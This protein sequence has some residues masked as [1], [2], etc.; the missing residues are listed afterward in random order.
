MNFYNSRN[1]HDLKMQ[2]SM[3]S[4][5]EPRRPVLLAQIA[6]PIRALVTSWQGRGARLST[7]ISQFKPRCVFQICRQ[8][9]GGL[10]AMSTSLAG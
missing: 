10:S 6:Y 1:L 5:C 7:L 8:V 2:T 3:R 4:I 9:P